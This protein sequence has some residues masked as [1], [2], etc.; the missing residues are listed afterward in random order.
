MALPGSGDVQAS[1]LVNLLGQA[2][3]FAWFEVGGL[4]DRWWSVA[5]CGLAVVVVLVQ[6][7]VPVGPV[8]V[9]VAGFAADV[10]A[11][12]AAGA[13]ATGTG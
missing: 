2:N 5:V 12:R 7:S 4:L 10:S 1:L 6:R 13:G 3:A 11:A 8:V 9:A